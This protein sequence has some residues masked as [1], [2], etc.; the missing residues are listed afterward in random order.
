MAPDLDIENKHADDQI[1]S[2]ASAADSTV[3]L[4]YSEYEFKLNRI[5]LYLNY[6]KADPRA[7]SRGGQP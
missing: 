4:T 5:I 7:L 3:T 2:A 6:S 1:L